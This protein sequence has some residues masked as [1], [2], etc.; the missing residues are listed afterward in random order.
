MILMTC[1][2]P[3]GLGH[4]FPRC[5]ECVWVELATG[6]KIRSSTQRLP[7]SLINRRLWSGNYDITHGAAAL[8]LAAFS[9]TVAACEAASRPA[10][11]CQQALLQQHS[12][13]QQCMQ[14]S[15]HS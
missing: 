4:K 8:G 5:F 2:L 13:Q 12:C 6:L 15:Q 10:M 9:L 14:H 1:G 7:S 11:A 3:P